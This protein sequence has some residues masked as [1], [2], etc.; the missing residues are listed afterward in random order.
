M[1]KGIELERYTAPGGAYRLVL[2]RIMFACVAYA[3]VEIKMDSKTALVE[4]T[5]HAKAAQDRFD[6]LK[7]KFLEESTK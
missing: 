1:N 3:V 7:E 5:R 2:N 4:N 6:A